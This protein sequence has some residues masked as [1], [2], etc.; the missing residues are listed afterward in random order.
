LEEIETESD[1]KDLESTFSKAKQKRANA[2][3]TTT[4]RPFFPPNSF[5]E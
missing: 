2:I 1:P 3:M 4:A 5:R